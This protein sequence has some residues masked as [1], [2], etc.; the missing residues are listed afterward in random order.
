MKKRIGTIDLNT[1]EI[2][3][4]TPVWVGKKARSPYGARWFMASQ[5]AVLELSKDKEITGEAFR[6]FMYL[7]SRI[8]F[9]NYIQ[10]PQKEIAADLELKSP[11][12]SRAISLLEKKRIIIRGPKVSRSSSF[13]LNEKYGWKGK[14]R[15][16]KL[17]K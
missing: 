1:G 6:V 8:D 14:V 9:E 2:L 3:E 13:R 12:I 7:C 17:V 10:V 5:D 16:L 11:N 15:N 4:G